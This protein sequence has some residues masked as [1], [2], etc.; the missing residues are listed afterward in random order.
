MILCPWREVT[1]CAPATLTDS[2]VRKAK[3][4]LAM[5]V[6][7]RATDTPFVKHIHPCRY[8]D[9]VVHRDAFRR[10]ATHPLRQRAHSPL[11]SVTDGQ[12]VSGR[13]PSPVKKAGRGA[14]PPALDAPR[15]GTHRTGSDGLG[16]IGRAY[17]LSEFFRGLAGTARLILPR[18]ARTLKAAVHG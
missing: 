15:K 1:T 6:R 18:R 13:P 3:I 8:A 4:T 2:I 5:T 12:L 17:E 16:P 14:G 7:L 11:A 9:S 10:V